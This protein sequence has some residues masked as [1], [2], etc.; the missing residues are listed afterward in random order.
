[1]GRKI[2]PLHLFLGFV[3]L[4][5]LIAFLVGGFVLGQNQSKKDASQT[6]TVTKAPTPTSNNNQGGKVCTQEVKQCPDGSW[7]GRTGPNCEFTPCP[8]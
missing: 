3:I 7:V 4:S 5:F 8:K 2:K 1:M 6:P